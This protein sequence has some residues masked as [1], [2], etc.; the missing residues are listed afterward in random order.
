MADLIKT[1]TDK[2]QFEFIFNNF[3][4]GNSVFIKTNSGNINLQFLGYSDGNAAF[5]I[6]LVKS[7]PDNVVVFVRRGHNNIYLSMKFVERSEDTFMFIPVKFQIISESRKED[8]KLLQVEGGGKSIMYVNNLVTEYMLHR[9]LSTS[10]KKIDKVKEVAEFELKKK[11]EY[12]KILFSFEAK[13]DQRFK[14][15]QSNS[16]PLYIPNLNEDPT[17]ELEEDFNHYINNIYRT[18]H[19]V[20]SRNKFIAEITAPIMYNEVIPYGYVQVNGMQPFTD[21][22]L[23]VCRRMT[24]VVDQ[25]LRKNNLLTPLSEKFLVSDLSAGGVGFVFK[26]KRLIRYFQEGS[27]VSFEI[28]LPTMKKAVMG[29]IVRNITFMENN[30]IKV[31]VQIDT[32][33]DKYRENYMEYVESGK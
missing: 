18:D 20:S 17:P 8:R 7:I 16:R 10:E 1:V 13:S 26:D 29:A 23:E 21:G 5:R 2:S 3:F 4:T 6:P 9:E 11:F 30:I 12:V 25:L 22:I 28:M 31:G 27:K 14:F 32:M 24:I 19:S 33:A 15:I